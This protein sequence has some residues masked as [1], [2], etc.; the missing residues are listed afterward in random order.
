MIQNGN[1]CGLQPEACV[2]FIVHV[3]FSGDVL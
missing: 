3:R 1:D 2:T